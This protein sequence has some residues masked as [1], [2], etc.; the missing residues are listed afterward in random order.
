[1]ES[2]QTAIAVFFNPRSENDCV[3]FKM[4]LLLKDKLGWPKLKTQCINLHNQ[5][6][7]LHGVSII[8][9]GLISMIY[10]IL[11]VSATPSSLFFSQKFTF[12]LPHSF[13]QT[14][15]HKTELTQAFNNSSM[16]HT[17]WVYCLG[18][19][20]TNNQASIPFGIPSTSSFLL[21]Y[22]SYICPSVFG[23]PW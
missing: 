14:Q 4:Q 10:S 15:H 8:P 13:I 7:I 1:M 16:E 6:K 3:Q 17:A 23:L 19:L 11:P 21:Y 12:P 5:I 18:C 20:S 9:W 22:H 2:N